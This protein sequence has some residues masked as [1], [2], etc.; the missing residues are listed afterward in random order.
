MVLDGEEINSFEEFVVFN[1]LNIFKTDSIGWI[2]LTKL[3]DKVDCSFVTNVAV[4]DLVRQDFGEDILVSCSLKHF[5][6]G[7]E[8]VNYAA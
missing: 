3:L 7:A 5:I 1:C 6:T 8:L 4:I 2:N